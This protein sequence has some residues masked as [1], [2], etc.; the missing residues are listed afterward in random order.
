MRAAWYERRGPAR[1]VLVV[2]ELPDPQPGPGEVRIQLTHSGIDPGDVGERSGRPGTPMPFPRVIPH[3]DGA[4]VL[5]TVRSRN[6]VERVR[7][8][9]AIEVF[10]ESDAELVGKL[11]TAAPAVIHRIAEIDFARHSR[12]DAQILAAG[13]VVSSYFST[14]PEPS[15]PYWEL[16]FADIT[17]RLLG[18]DDFRPEVK[19]HAPS[20]L[21]DALVD[22]ALRIP[23]AARLPLEQ[24][25]QAH[26]L[27]EE[28]VA[29]R[30]VL[31]L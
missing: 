8:L 6:D 11:R 10:L 25:A 1:Q 2:G 7:A 16:G 20:E 19:A 23:I 31:E 14:H 3:S 28:G 26:E 22:G 27:V 24:I 30:V 13:G 15:I 29:G 4:R 9:G 5:T 17:L 18:S 12:L 21:T